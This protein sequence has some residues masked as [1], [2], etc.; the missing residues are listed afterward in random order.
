MPYACSVI[1]LEK[2]C[3]DCDTTGKSIS[4]L[5]KRCP[6]SSSA[7]LVCKKRLKINHISSFLKHLKILYLH[8]HLLIDNAFASSCLDVLDEFCPGFGPAL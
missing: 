8:L 5:K 4:K 2:K 3:Y 6:F 7:I 1:K